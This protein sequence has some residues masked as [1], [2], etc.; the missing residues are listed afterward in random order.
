[1]KLRSLKVDKNTVLGIVAFLVI[2][3][4]DAGFAVTHW[5]VWIHWTWTAIF[6]HFAKITVAVFL[7]WLLSA[8]ATEHLLRDRNRNR[9]ERSRPAAYV[10]CSI[11]VLSFSVVA[12]LI[13]ATPVEPGD[14]IESTGQVATEYRPPMPEHKRDALIEKIFWVSLLPAMFGVRC[15]LGPKKRA[16]IGGT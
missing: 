4:L 8:G 9:I 6:S 15:A 3:L 7:V 14:E 13:I 11:V 10:L 16:G 2:V 12:G 5:A 1:M